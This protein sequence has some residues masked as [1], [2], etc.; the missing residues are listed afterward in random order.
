MIS[1]KNNGKIYQ[2]FE[3]QICDS[4][5]FI[6]ITKYFDAVFISRYNLFKCTSTKNI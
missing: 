2:K 6:G 3:N 1:I 5:V 4:V